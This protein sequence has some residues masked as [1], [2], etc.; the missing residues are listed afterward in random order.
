MPTCTHVIAYS[1]PAG[2]TAHVARVIGEELANQGQ[3]AQDH[4]LWQG[5]WRNGLPAPLAA[6]DGPV[7]VWAGSPV[8][9][10]HALP[11]VTEFLQTLPPGRGY[12]VPFVTWGAV[13][14]GT[15]LVEMGTTLE[16][17]GWPLL[18]AG[19][20]LAVHS[21]LLESEHPLGQGH[22]D[23]ADDSLIRDLVQQVLKKLS[24][25]EPVRPLDLEALNYQPEW[26]REKSSK[27]SLEVVK[28]SAHPGFEIDEQACT[29]CGICADSC[30]TGAIDL[31]PYPAMGPECI[32]CNTCV[33]ECPE[34]AIH[35]QG[36]VEDRE[37]RLRAMAEEHSESPGSKIFV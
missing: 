16:D 15:A 31:Q 21:G 36:S 27:L 28:Q 26:V 9:A 23:A 7:C 10:H 33:R 12:G 25:P 2:S 13:T 35:V 24:G 32:L 19:K 34:E 5:H 18:G 3:E 14:S 17:R 4:E 11:Q 30:P 1:S 37:K 20:V 8:Y 22:P 6:G 29:Q